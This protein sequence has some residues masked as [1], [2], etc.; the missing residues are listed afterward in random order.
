MV[1]R[2]GDVQGYPCLVRVGH[3]RAVWRTE[4]RLH[5]EQGNHLVLSEIENLEEMTPFIESTGKTFALT[6]LESG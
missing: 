5:L 6:A 4:Q 2:E 3:P 1:E